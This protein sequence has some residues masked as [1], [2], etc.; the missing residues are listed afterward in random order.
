ML[1]EYVGE[2]FNEVLVFSCTSLVDLVDDDVLCSLLANHYSRR[3]WLTD[4]HSS[5]WRLT[6]GRRAREEPRAQ[7]WRPFQ[8]SMLIA[9]RGFILVR[10]GV[11]RS[12]DP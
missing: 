6:R 4:L 5:A 11:L 3:G 10:N 1:Q 12:D 8:P 7:V 9:A 2:N